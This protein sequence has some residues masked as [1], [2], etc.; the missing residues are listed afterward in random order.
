MKLCKIDEL[1]GDE[2]LARAVYTRDFT[3][4][5]SEGTRLKQE[6]IEKLKEMQ[7]QEVYIETKAV[8][9]T[10]EIHILTDDI[11]KKYKRKVRSI[12]ERH[13]YQQNENLIELRETAENIISNVLEE[14]E[15]VEKV[16]DIR[17]RSADVYEHSLSVCTLCTL[18]AIR[19]GLSQEKI[20]E[21]SIGA[22]LHD[23]G[24]RYLTIDFENR[25]IEEMD[26]VEAAEFRKHP[27]YGYTALKKEE[28]VSD[29]SRNVVLY[30]HERMDGSGYP[31]KA[32][33]LPI[34]ARIVGCCDAFDEMICGIGRKRA[35]VHEAVEFLKNFWG[36]LFDPGVV[37]VFLEFTAVYPAGTYVLTNEGEEGIVIR[38]NAHFPDRPVLRIVKDREGKEPSGEVVKDLLQEKI[39]F[40]EK[41]IR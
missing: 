29:V 11:E 17:E 7:I 15:V 40:I 31:L 36:V 28:W 10:S 30:H 41:V 12:L 33:D 8:Y 16:Y 35:K 23:L 1:K 32:K 2:T 6:Y 18:V 39:I 34:E 24:L 22:L 19:L 26:S 27:V 21:I 9:D 13:T 20:R 5:L 25:Y 4:L 3:I 14:K 37:D 38:Q